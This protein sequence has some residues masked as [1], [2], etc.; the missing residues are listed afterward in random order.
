MKPIEELVNTISKYQDVVIHHTFTSKKHSVAQVSIQGK[1]RVLKWYAPGYKK[2]I[3]KE[4]EI[5]Q[6]AVSSL[7][8]PQ[9]FEYD[10]DNNVLILEYI[11]AENLCDYLND[12][13]KTL[14]QKKKALCLLVDWFHS[15]HHQFMTKTSHFIHG[16]PTLR[17]F[18]INNKIWGVDFEESRPGEPILDIAG[19]CASLLTTDPMF[20]NEKNK[21]SQ[22]FIQQY[23][24]YA[25]GTVQNIYQ[26]ISLALLEKIP[27]RPQDE[28]LLRTKA[29]LI[30]KEGLL[31]Q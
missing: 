13:S 5:L 30:K 12:D 8:V 23:S 28:Q 27:W 11:S 15:F 4:N 25:P 1:T 19:V 29:S 18:L 21:L 26:E 16:D 17:N 3:E 6:K 24:A 2:N 9:V 31:L 10:Q 22:F 14:E 20:T 7:Q